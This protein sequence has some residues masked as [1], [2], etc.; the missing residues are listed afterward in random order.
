MPQP[1]R[2]GLLFR[3][4]FVQK[5]DK[6]VTL[7]PLFDT[8]VVK[9]EISKKQER[10]FELARRLAYQSDYEGFRHGAILLRGGSVI[11]ASFNKSNFCS[12]GQQFREP[13][14]GSATLHAELGTILGVDRSR[15]QGSDVYVARINNDG[16]FRMS[17]PCPMCQNA[18]RYCGVSR[19]YY[20]TGEGS[21][22]EMM[23]L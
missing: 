7:G 13:N 14:T 1:A 22:I 15:T 11:N 8:F 5:A 21:G 19:V 23:K 17:K 18:M 4:E 2:T 12:F 9:M 3:S 16:V 6:S 20:T 10:Y